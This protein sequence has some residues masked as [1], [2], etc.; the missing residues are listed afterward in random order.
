MEPYSQETGAHPP[1]LGMDAERTDIMAA[2]EARFLE[3]L[4]VAPTYPDTLL[5]QCEE[6]A[7]VKERREDYAQNKARMFDELAGKREPLVIIDFGTAPDPGSDSGETR[8]RR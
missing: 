4:A 8:L 7:V 2:Q 5:H 6:T 3:N 1:Y